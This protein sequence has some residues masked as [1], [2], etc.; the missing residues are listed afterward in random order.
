MVPAQLANKI[1]LDSNKQ[2][3]A[4]FDSVLKAN[5]PP[6]TQWTSLVL[7]LIGSRACL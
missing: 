1:S 5:D 3:D 4:I 6:E 2:L 7:P